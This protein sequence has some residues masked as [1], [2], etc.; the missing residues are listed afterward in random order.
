MGAHFDSLTAIDNDGALSMRVVCSMPIRTFIE[1]GTVGEELFA[2]GVGHASER[3]LPNFVK[4][5]LDGV[6]TTRTTALLTPYKCVHA[7]DD[8]E[9]RGEPY[10]TL[11]DLV[12]SLRRCAELGLGAK[13]HATGD[14][15]VRLALEAAA[16]VRQDA[17]GGPVMQIAH[18]SFIAEDDVARFAELGVFADA[19]PFMWFPSPLVDG[20]GAFVADETMSRIWPFRDLLA[21][22]ATIAGGSDWPV[23]LPVLNPWMGIEGMV[24][25]RG[26]VE[27]GDDR[28][29]NLD[30]AITVQQA[31][32]A[33]TRDSARALGVEAV[34]GTLEVGKSADFILVDRDVFSVPV[35]EIHLTQVRETWFAG[36]RM[37]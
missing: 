16:V 10:W 12:T 33:F 3:I 35:A 8:P 23:G 5:V 2:K 37:N 15:S 9:F 29:V 14:A 18:M 1:E 34:T 27:G 11:D 7:D 17:N 19:C 20:V 4:F 31:V 26:P 24:T 30:Q 6:P 21:S 22:G 36:K 25:R 13:L 28:A 32:A